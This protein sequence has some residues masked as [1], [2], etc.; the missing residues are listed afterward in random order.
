MLRM[1]STRFAE[2]RHSLICHRQFDRR[3]G[4]DRCPHSGY[5]APV[6]WI[7]LFIGIGV[8]HAAMLSAYA[9][10]SAQRRSGHAWLAS[11]F[12][13]LAIVVTAILITHRTEGLIESIAMLFEGAA[14]WLAGPVLYAYMRDA[15]DR[16]LSPRGLALHFG[17]CLVLIVAYTLIQLA[18][19][20]PQAQWAVAPYEL[21][22]SIASALA[23]A[24]GR[25]ATDRSARGFWWP[26]GSLA[27][28]FSVHAGQL[29][30]LF[31]PRAA[32]DL[33]PLIGAFAASLI[34]LAL[35]VSQ[36]QRVAGP[37]YA[38]SSLKREELERI[39]TVLQRTLDGP[40]PLYLDLDLSLA[41]LSGA[42]N[43]PVHHASQAIS[44]IGCGSFYDMLTARRVAE[45]QR[46]LLAPENA[47]ISVDALGSESGF[48]SRS[49]FYAAFKAATGAT[50]AD[51]RKRRGAI[52]S[53]TAG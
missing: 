2:L 31:E 3:L 37:R 17:V 10:A 51:F 40:P 45:A 27:V 30:R 19:P 36:A 35:L 18:I 42:A 23:F 5:G 16:P 34:L 24:R 48:R 28:M 50:P 11:L 49:A 21:C 7:S 8:A 22:Y 9:A 4:L 38:R 25:R 15:I 47:Q 32:E 14:A 26:I 43:V 20:W 6:D 46:R 52:V 1:L 13:I 29:V 41:R 33:V 44:E 12:A 53:G 39:Y